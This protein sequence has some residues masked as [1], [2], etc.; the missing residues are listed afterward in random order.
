MILRGL[1]SV[2]RWVI[3]FLEELGRF[4]GM[5]GR[6]LAWA[7]RPPYDVPEWFRQMVR[8]GV[9]SIPLVFLTTLFTGMVNSTPM[10]PNARRNDPAHRTPFPFPS[11]LR[12]ERIGG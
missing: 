8:V 6:I 2:G 9:D 7:P 12:S 3:R 10:S 4:F 11:R 5:L 1:E